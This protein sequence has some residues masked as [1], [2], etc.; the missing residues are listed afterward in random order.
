MENREPSVRFVMELD[1]PRKAVLNFNVICRAEELSGVDLIGGMFSFQSARVLRAL[2]MA[3][4]EEG[5]NAIE[6]QTEPLTLPMVGLLITGKTQEV[7][8]LMID[9][10]VAA[11]PPPELAKEFEADPRKAEAAKS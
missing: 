9:K 8:E 3:A 11:F 6:R 1:R 4:L 2:V 7:L 10:W 5:Q